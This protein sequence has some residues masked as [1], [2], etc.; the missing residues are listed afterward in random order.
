MKKI[1][2]ISFLF[3]FFLYGTLFAQTPP[4]ANNDSNT[5]ELNTTIS[6]T[7]PGVLANDSDADGDTLTI[8]IFTINSDTYNVGDTVN[9]TEGDFTLND[10][11]SYTFIST[12]D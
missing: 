1:T 2:P 8:T 3:F 4:V 12:T 11:G 9:L 7:E 10:D 5:V 6:V